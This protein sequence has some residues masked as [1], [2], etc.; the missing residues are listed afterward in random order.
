MKLKP[1]HMLGAM[2]AVAGLTGAAIAADAEDLKVFSEAKISLVKAIE[3]AER[4]Q[5]GKAIDAGIDDDSFTPAYEVSVVKD[6]RVY[7]VRVDAVNGTV[8]GVREDKDD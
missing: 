6:A 1:V 3:V 7:D 5:G 4:H 8:V 2:A